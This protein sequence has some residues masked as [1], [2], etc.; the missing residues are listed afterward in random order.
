MEQLDNDLFTY[1]RAAL[2]VVRRRAG[3]RENAKADL[4][5]DLRAG[6]IR[7]I[8]FESTSLHSRIHKVGGKPKYLQYISPRF[9]QV[10][11]DQDTSTWDWEKGD[12]SLLSPYAEL[13]GASSSW[14]DVRFE[15][16]LLVEVGK[17]A[18]TRGR[19]RS[20]NWTDWIAA[21][22]ILAADGDIPSNLR[23]SELQARIRDKL[24]GWGCGELAPSTTLD[25]AKAILKR[26]R[27]D[28]PNF[29]Q[30]S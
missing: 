6:F 11:T 17:P 12:F 16:N 22:V 28:D 3:S 7:S 19:K 10:A 2:D 23:E 20:P 9:W 30:N 29:P 4:L 14:N 13:S 21:A 27:S 26:V 5:A 18:S 8:G 15:T 25:A 1:S 24:D